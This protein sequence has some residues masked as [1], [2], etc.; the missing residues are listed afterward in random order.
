MA[1]KLEVQY[2]AV[3]QGYDPDGNLYTDVG[4]VYES[5]EAAA[6]VR[7]KAVIVEAS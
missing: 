2:H 4:D 7:V 1:P 6:P 5:P 3:E